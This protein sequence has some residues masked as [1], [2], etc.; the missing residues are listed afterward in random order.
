MCSLDPS[1]LFLLKAASLDDKIHQDCIHISPLEGFEHAETG[2]IKMNE[3][4]K[5]LTLPNGVKI[6][7]EEIIALAGDYYG[8]PNQPIID[9][10]FKDI[11]QEDSGRHQRFRDAY[12]TLART[13]KTDELQNELDKLL[14][15][16]HKEIKTGVTVDA[17]TWDEITGGWWVAGL[18]VKLGRMMQ[19]AET[20]F[21]HFLPNAKN[22]Y[23]T[24]HQLAI[25]KAREA[26]NY[27]EDDKDEQKRLLHEAFSLEAFSCH[28]LTD[29]FASGHIR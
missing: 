6:K 4:L 8:L 20:N 15:T 14:A 9:P 22:A 18:P 12:S 16:L 11:D 3:E 29:S 17:S 7:F 25:D 24:G 13:P 10:A 23:L 21:D 1:R 2:K 26:G 5:I 28:F 27:S 19:L